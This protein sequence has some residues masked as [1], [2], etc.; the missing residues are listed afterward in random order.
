M[1]LRNKS[2][3]HETSLGI[4]NSIKEILFDHIVTNSFSA[5][6]LCQSYSFFVTTYL[7]S[8]HSALF[9]YGVRQGCIVTFSSN[10]ETLL[11]FL[12]NK[13]R[14][15]KKKKTGEKISNKEALHL[16]HNVNSMFFSS[17]C[18]VFRVLVKTA[19]TQ[20]GRLNKESQH[21]KTKRR[22]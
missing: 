20:L 19:S 11:F 12:S 16:T 18:S 13:E 6:F 7:F 3:I 10:K 17:I 5:V 2:L 15:K 22:M 4:Y 21:V 1:S 14:K 8:P 9:I